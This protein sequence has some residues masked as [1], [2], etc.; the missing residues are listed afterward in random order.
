MKIPAIKHEKAVF[1]AAAIYPVLLEIALYFNVVWYVQ[2]FNILL[3]SIVYGLFIVLFRKIKP[4]MITITVIMLALSIANEF[5]INARSVAFQL[6]DFFCLSDAIRLSGRYSFMITWGMVRDFLLCAGLLTVMMVLL[7]QYDDKQCRRKKFCGGATVLCIALPLSMFGG[8]ENHNDGDIKFDINTFTKENGVLYS[9]FVELKS[10]AVEAPVNYSQ[11]KAKEKL[12]WNNHSNHEGMPNIIVVMNESLTDYDYV[13][14][15]PLTQDVL[16]FIHS[17]EENC[18]KGRA[19]AS[20]FGGYTCNSEWE[21][22]TGNSMA[23]LSVTSVPYNQLID[24]E[25][26][27]LASSLRSLG[28]ATCAIHPYY[29]VEWNRAENYPLMGFDEFITGPDFGDGSGEVPEGMDEDLYFGDLDYIRGFISDSENYRKVMEVMEEKD[30]ET[31]QFIFTVTIQNHGSYGYEGED[32]ESIEIC[33]GAGDEVNQY[34]T[35]AHESDRAFEELI[36]YFEEYPE[37]TIILMFGDHQPALAMPYETLYADASNEVAVRETNYTIP[38][39]MWANY[40]VDWEEQEQISLNYLSALLKQNAGLALD[41]WDSFRLKAM[42][43]YP[44]LN[45]Y[46]VLDGTRTF[47]SLNETLESSSVLQE[48]EQLQYYRIFDA[49]EATE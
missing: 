10:Y 41:S 26:D 12:E 34:L 23:F 49:A 29:G 40:D 47:L 48:Y 25:T 46:G 42:E 44:V 11:E 19:Y 28:Y 13:G 32:F 31:P 45:S 39:I 36:T 20:V 8:I 9:L 17:M 35:V 27:S 30:P 1:A 24:H 6:S 15:L 4:A 18:I 14:E 2:I 38:Y 43:E 22:L 37:D 5:S 16:P 3:L 33:E 21:F 7:R